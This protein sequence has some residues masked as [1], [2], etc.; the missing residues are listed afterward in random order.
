MFCKKDRDSGSQKNL[1][2]RRSRLRRH[3]FQFFLS[4]FLLFFIF[5]FYFIF[6]YVRHKK[7]GDAPFAVVKDGEARE[8]ESGDEP[9][10]V[11]H[12]DRD[13]SFF[14]ERKTARQPGDSSECEFAFTVL[15]SGA[16]DTNGHRCDFDFR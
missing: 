11:F 13:G 12:R 5:Y 8:E 1:Q 15:G 7:E 3:L 9:T 16:Y 10:R 6:L 4:T 2:K 14:T